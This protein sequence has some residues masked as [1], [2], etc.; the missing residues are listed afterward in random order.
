MSSVAVKNAETANP[1]PL[2]RLH[3][4]ILAGVVYILG[5]LAILFKLLPTL[6]WDIFGL[7]H[8]PVATALLLIVGTVAAAG[9]VVLGVRMLGRQPA[10]GVKAGIFTTLVV[11]LAIVLITRALSL[12]FEGMVY[13]SATL[14]E[15]LGIGLTVGVAVLLLVL[16]I[17]FLFLASSFGA[18][19]VAF[20][21]QGW[22]SATSFKRSQGQRVRRGTMVG[23]LVLAGCGIWA[24]DPTHNPRL[25]GSW[26]INIP[27]TGKA[28]VTALNDAVATLGS[29][30]PTDEN[31][32]P[33]LPHTVDLGTFRQKNAELKSGY[34]KVDDP[35]D[36]ELRKGE[37]VSKTKF[38][39][40]AEPFRDKKGAGK[41]PSISA[42]G[43]DPAVATFSY[44]S[45]TLL[46]DIRFT[47]PILVAALALW[48]AWRVVNVPM[49][50]DFLIATEAELN[51]VSWTTR[52]RLIQDTIVVLI[53]V[54]LF[55][56]FLFVVDV[57]WGQVLSWKAIGVLK[58]NESEGAGQKPGEQ[59][60]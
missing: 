46:P 19:M 33:Q 27:F 32:Q 22:F 50:G 30:V 9:L 20:E 29:K 3:V 41:E 58:F 4:G 48:F 40:A 38:E 26:A 43:P 36:S 8:T 15:S 28:Q 24:L 37:V 35:G 34:V 57:A 17:R 52:P 16:A 49:F 47:V 60:W 11:V 59:K 54:V 23:I 18:R 1:S 25:S 21:E 7:P 56:L 51:K 45:L 44:A 42:K 12:W 6:W 55:T 10:P 2:D 13:D 31:G 14:P 53:T 39:E 5:G